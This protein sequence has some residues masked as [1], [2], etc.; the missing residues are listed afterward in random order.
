MKIALVG[1]AGSGKDYL[2]NKLKE[3]YGYET[4][5]FATSLKKACVEIFPFMET[6][7]SHEVKDAPIGYVS[8]NGSTFEVPFS[9]RDI[10]LSVSK[11]IREVYDD[12]WIHK[13]LEIVDR[14]DSIIITDLRT[15]NEF[16]HCKERG[17]VTIWIEPHQGI[18]N[19]E[20]NSYDMENVLKLREQCDLFYNNQHDRNIGSFFEIIN[21]AIFIW[22]N[23]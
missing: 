5:A 23:Q 20:L 8:V 19:C 6:D 17:I 3:N 16:N 1:I 10:W 12:I 7:P 14:T 4:I 15:Q 13:T 21:L 9:H 18:E 2:A 22:S 11:A